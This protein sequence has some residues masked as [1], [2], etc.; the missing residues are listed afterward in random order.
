MD[1]ISAGTRKLIA[2]LQQAKHRRREGL[3]VIEGT[4]AV[5]DTAPFFKVASIVATRQWLDAHSHELPPGVQI[6]VAGIDDMSRMSSL[7]TPQGVLAV[8]HVREPH[9]IPHTLS[10]NGLM[11]A[12]DTVQDPGN[13]G[14]IIR[15]ADW[16]GVTHILASS[17]TADIYNPKTVQASMGAIARVEVHYCKLAET[18]KQLSD[19]VPVYGT[20]PN[21]D[22][23]Y[24]AQLSQGGIVVFGNEGNGISPAVEA[25]VQRRLTIPVYPAGRDAIESLNVSMAAGITLAEFRRRSRQQQ[26]QT[27]MHTAQAAT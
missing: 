18:L 27:G 1:S 16:F 24:A 15:V 2:S 11:L 26:L 7:T 5:I 3:F 20:F 6:A 17:D 12:L 9:P 23:I 25:T 10:G 19:S 4:R 14:T 22:D 8:C 13:L 21:G